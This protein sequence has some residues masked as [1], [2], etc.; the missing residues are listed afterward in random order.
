MSSRMTSGLDMSD[1]TMGL[2]S[3]W[4]SMSGFDITWFCICDCNSAKFELPSPNEPRLLSRP[5]VPPPPAA[6]PRP[7]NGRLNRFPSGF[8]GCCCGVGVAC[9]PPLVLLLVVVEGVDV[10]VVLLAVDVVAPPLAPSDFK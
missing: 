6:P 2:S 9:C 3:I 5:P 7:P 4:R 1:C 8:A 10:V